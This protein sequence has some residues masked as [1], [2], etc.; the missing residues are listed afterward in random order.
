MKKSI[1]VYLHLENTNITA[2]RKY[3]NNDDDEY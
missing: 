2:I 3:V 1:L